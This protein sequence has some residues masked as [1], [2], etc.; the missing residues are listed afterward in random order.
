MI[1]HRC[2][3]IL[4]AISTA[5]AAQPPDVDSPSA[6]PVAVD[7]LD[8]VDAIQT[9]AEAE[10]W[11]PHDA[12]AYIQIAPAD[13]WLDHPLRERIAESDAFQRIWTSPD[14]LNARTGLLA[15]EWAT[16]I[17]LE[18]FLKQLSAGGVYGAIDADARGFVVLARTRDQK[19]LQRTMAKLLEF[20]RNSQKNKAGDGE[21]DGEIKSAEYRGIQ[22]Y[23]INNALVAPIGPWLVLSN[24][25]ELLKSVLDRHLDG[26]PATLADASWRV[27]ATH[28]PRATPVDTGDIST[29]I[30][31]AT[32]EIDLSRARTLMSSNDLFQKQAKDFGAELLLGGIL[33]LLQN[34]P[35][36]AMELGMGD[37]ALTASVS[38]PTQM[39]WFADAR[40][41]YVGPQGQGKS[42]PLIEMDGALGSLSTYRN[43]SELWLRAGDLF[44]QKVND[45]LAQADNTLTTLFSG[46]DFGTEILGAIEPELRMIAVPQTWAS[47]QLQPSLKLPAFALVARLKEPD[48]MR[49]ELKR[50][51]QS[52]IGFLNVVGAMEGNPQFDLMSEMLEK[53]PVYWGEYVIDADRNYENGLPIQYN[54]APAIAFSGDRVILSSHT[55][56]ARQWLLHGDRSEESSSPS[57]TPTNTSLVIHAE[58]VRQLLSANRDNLIAQNMLEKGHSRAQA[59]KEIEQLLSILELIDRVELDLSFDARSLLQLRVDYR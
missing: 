58:T 56:L 40:E 25:S 5:A 4:L 23:K 19:W 33:A 3:A 41:H 11:L 53:G 34:A 18:T 36:A 28:G 2:I 39:E 32:A 12:L 13:V 22:G 43:L 8:K 42:L 17:K 9:K 14:V 35:S 54:F 51:F 21:S 10:R 26:G 16:G 45:Q 46:R 48:V 6:E 47:D 52:F 44:D 57:A 37:D 30:P 27:S 50:I 55:A 7:R 24:R 31:I 20:A 29:T 49:K 38:F 15:A 59:V 1:C